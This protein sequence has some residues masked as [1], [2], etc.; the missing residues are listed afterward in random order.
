[1]H[2]RN[3][4]HARDESPLDGACGCAVCDRWSRAYLRHLHLVGEP[5]AA[6]LLTIHNLTWLLALVARA[7]AAV[8]DGTVATLRR[9]VSAT[10][11]RKSGG[12]R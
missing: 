5:G 8:V 12:A 9:E 7:R 10:W 1:L 6:R 3:A 2:V 4:A 11:A